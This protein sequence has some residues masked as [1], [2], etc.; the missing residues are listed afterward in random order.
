MSFWL[1]SHH[2]FLNIKTLEM[3]LL[4]YFPAEPEE[5][6]VTFLLV[7]ESDEKSDEKSCH[8]TPLTPKDPDMSDYTPLYS[9][10]GWWLNQPLW[11]NMLVQLEIFPKYG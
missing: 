7:K 11:K 2:G 6:D 4:F 9:Y 3:L 10:S 1:E 5:E 8:G